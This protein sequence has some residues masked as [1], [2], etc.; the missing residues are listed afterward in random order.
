M[1]VSMTKEVALLEVSIADTWIC[2]WMIYITLVSSIMTARN[3]FTFLA[4][5]FVQDLFRD[6]LSWLIHAGAHCLWGCCSYVS[7]L[8]Y[9]GR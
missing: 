2:R 3:R 6:S 5:S 7:S 4:M 9:D 8:I 1:K